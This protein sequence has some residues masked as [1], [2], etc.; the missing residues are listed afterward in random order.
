VGLVESFVRNP[1]KVA[2]GII[3]LLLF[4][5]IALTRMPMQLTPEV[6]APT[7]TIE[8]MWPGASPQ[9]VEREIVQEQEEQLKG[10]EGVLKMTGECMDS[11]GRVTLEFIVGT[12]MS[13]ALLKVNTRL[14]QVREYPEEADEPVLKTSNSADSPIA[15]L[16][17]RPRLP[18]VAEL[19]TFLETHPNLR[20]ALTPTLRATNSGQKQR[21]L[22]AAAAAHPEIVPLLPKALNLQH[23]QR[24]AEDHIEARFERIPGV[25]NSNV[26]GGQEEELQIIVDPQR[27]ADRRLTIADVRRALRA[28]N[29]DTSGGDLWEGKRRYV[30]RT[31]GQF[32]GIEE[33]EGL[34]LVRR[35]GATVHLRDIAEVRRGYKKPT[36]V[37]QNFGMTVLA[38]N[39]VRE[40][41]ANVLEVMDG[42]YRAREE[43]NEGILKERG[44]QL[45]QVYD[46]TEYI[47]SAIGLVRQSIVIGGILTI[48]VLLL[49]LRSGR[50]TLVIALAIPTSIVGT[51]LLLN[52]MGRSLNVISLAGLAFAVG[53]LVDNAVVVLENV[54]RR[55]QMGE[56]RVTAAV[57]GTQEV[58]GAVVASTLTTLAVFLPIL[59]VE[60]EAGQ[61]F[62]DIALA[63]SCS[64][65]LSLIISVTL[66]PTLTSRILSTQHGGMAGEARA[67]ASRNPIAHALHKLI[68]PLDAL[69]RGFVGAITRAHL[70]LQEGVVRQLVLVAV[71]VGGAVLSSIALFPKVEY[72]PTGNRNLAFGIVLPPPGYN[73]DQLVAMGRGIEKK[74]QPYWDVDPGV[75]R[76]EGLDGPVIEHFFFVAR[77]R[78]VFM[79]MRARDPLRAAELV[80][81]IQR[82]GAGL[83]GTMVVG[84]QSSLFER[85]LSAGRTI[86]I[87]ISGPDL[88]GL[89][90]V[91]GRV[92]GM[93]QAAIPGS[94]PIP[95]P[96]LDLSNPEVHIRLKWE[97][98]ED[99]GVTAA[100]L[101]YTVNSLVDGAYAGDYFVGGDK[102]DLTIMGQPRFAARVQD[103]E[104][105]PIATPSGDV[106]PL[107]A[108]AEVT[109][110]SG[111]EQINHRERQRAVTIQ[112]SPP[113]GMALEDA[114]ERIDAQVLKPLTEQGV[115]G[116][117]Y[118]ATLSGTADKL[119]A[120]WRALR[121]N[122]FLALLITY[123]LLAA[124]FES[125]ASIPGAYPTRGSVPPRSGAL[126]H[127]N[128]HPADLHDGHHDG[129]RPAPARALSGGGQRALPRPGQRADR[130]LARLHALHPLPRAHA[131]A[132]DPGRARTSRARRRGTASRIGRAVTEALAR[133]MQGPHGVPAL[134]PRAR[135]RGLPAHLRGDRMGLD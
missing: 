106:V 112:V 30:V 19:E 61:L 60:E 37:V 103:L 125:C 119:I 127:P 67:P 95:K 93:V 91:G 62:R 97:K 18:T 132:I 34:V 25:S 21:R 74:L 1:I 129:L 59:F 134:R 5:G 49:F 63:I 88:P 55:Y 85:G 117:A 3:L 56:R 29:R 11:M 83:P 38:V 43:L 4:G 32:K 28:R 94:Q 66:I 36:G 92:Y 89:V 23:W 72:L 10:V 47:Y 45:D 90:A 50:S 79:G 99:M 121:N 9:E 48:L 96:S 22:E 27:L 14:Q 65:G 57:K 26:L 118:R 84:K 12:D 124:L 81:I 31:L 41:S 100:S 58:W 52:L 98:A 54:Y 101:G 77:G 135:H 6:T 7:I 78:S 33:V 116:G 109:L 111:P 123:L 40:S 105:L 17:L 16:I 107:R 20:E 86:D 69:A 13:A 87:E 64:V 82:M 128:A 76:P 114:L 51:F 102:I 126:G 80:P 70:W 24:F 73:L 115:I 113:E 44:L 39:C 75:T 133:G 53:M 15:W 2:V 110:G 46:E 130:R 122:I 42:I 71:L 120:T 104:D 8:T 68:S 35:E 108:V 131:A